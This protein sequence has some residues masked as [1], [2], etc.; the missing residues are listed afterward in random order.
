[1]LRAQGKL[2]EMIPADACC[3][4]AHPMLLRSP[5]DLSVNGGM[6]QTQ[7][8]GNQRLFVYSACFQKGPIH[9]LLLQLGMTSL[10]IEIL[11]GCAY[12]GDVV[13]GHSHRRH[14]LHQ[15]EVHQRVALFL[16]KLRGHLLVIICHWCLLHFLLPRPTQYRWILLMLHQTR[17][18]Y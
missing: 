14:H 1:M 9:R 12:D 5:S 2:K 17:P 11:G 13:F 4:F 18:H 7:S 8:D 16:E 3:V 6:L 15:S 10:W